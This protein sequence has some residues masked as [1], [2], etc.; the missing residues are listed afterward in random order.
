[1]PFY[2]WIGN[3]ILTRLQN[4]ILGSD[5]SEFHTGYR[6]Y[7]VKALAE[8]PFKYNSNYFDFDTDIIIQLLDTYKRIAEFPIP[9]YYGDEISRVN[10]LRYAWLVVKSSLQSRVVPRGIYYHPKFDYAV[11]NSYY[12]LKLGYTSSHQFALDHIE[13]GATVLDIGCGPGYMTEQLVNRGAEVISIDRTILPRV[14]EL[15]KETLE[16]DVDVVDFEELE[17]SVQTILALDIIEHLRYPEAFLNRLRE[18]YAQDGASV[19]ITTGN[20]AFLIIRLSLFLGQFNYGKRGILDL[21]HTHLFT[22]SSLR[23]MLTHAG[24][25]VVEEQGIPAP[26]PLALG[27]GKLARF[28]LAVNKFF[29]RL[30]KGMF[31]YQVAFVAKPQ[32]TLDDL[33]DH[34]ER[35]G[36][37]K[38]LEYTV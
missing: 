35:S 10:G 27:D 17:S 21:D 18:R 8:I 28:L 1:M 22:F 12:T 9:T 38:R 34:A 36:E 15:S 31:S 32:L 13:A 3:Q 24:Y 26:F 6:A 4:R 16:A 5:L 25:E 29:I 7:S 20:V 33:L 2:K 23:R 37:A 19:I 14:E 11:D 30:R